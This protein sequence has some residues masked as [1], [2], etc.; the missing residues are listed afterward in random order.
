MALVQSADSFAKKHY[1]RTVYTICT[2]TVAHDSKIFF[3]SPPS[4]ARRLHK[5]G[6][7]AQNSTEVHTYNYIT[8]IIIKKR[9]NH[10][11]DYWY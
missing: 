6:R 1:I 7:T 3:L 8:R 9:Y 5:Y 11:K 2:D 10:G 4:L